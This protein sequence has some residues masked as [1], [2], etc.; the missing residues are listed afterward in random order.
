VFE[1]SVES[2]LTQWRP[3]A[4]DVI[5]FPRTEGSPLLECRAAGVIFG[6]LERTG[7]YTA[8]VGPAK[9]ILHLNT[10]AVVSCNVQ[11]KKLEVLG[12]SRLQATG[13]IVLR[14]QQMVIIDAGTPLVVG[15]F[16][17]LL[18]TLAAGDWVTVAALPPVHGFVVPTTR[19]ALATVHSEI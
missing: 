1:E 18:D 12:P 14:Q 16:A 10:E 15:S 8:P 11:E 2:F 9:L 17:P 13:L 7:P 4:A 5:L 19:T 6:V 3:Y